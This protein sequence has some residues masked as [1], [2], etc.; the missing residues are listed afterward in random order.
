M[1]I[2]YID[3]A[4]FWVICDSDTYV[5]HGHAHLCVR[6]LMLVE[7]ALSCVSVNINLPL[8]LP[9]LDGMLCSVNLRMRR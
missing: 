7:C 1:E 2:D 3:V 8:L 5:T 6:V 9:L 4:I